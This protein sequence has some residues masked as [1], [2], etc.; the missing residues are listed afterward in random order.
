[1]TGL[2]GVLALHQWEFD[3]KWFCK[4]GAEIPTGNDAGMAVHQTEAVI[5]A[6][7]VVTK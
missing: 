1:M 2:A 4:C 6:G 7:F 3:N 5:D